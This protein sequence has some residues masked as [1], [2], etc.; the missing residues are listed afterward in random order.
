MRG[1][2]D[3]PVL[4]PEIPRRNAHGN[5][6]RLGKPVHPLASDLDG[7]REVDDVARPRSDLLE[8]DP[9]LDDRADGDGPLRFRDA[10]GL[11]PLRAGAVSLLEEELSS[12]VDEAKGRGP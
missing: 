1:R 2:L 3:A 6:S 12:G 7:D 11:L 4:S 9:R 5:V 10:V 8:R